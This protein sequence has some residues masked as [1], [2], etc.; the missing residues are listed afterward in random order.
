[1]KKIATSLLVILLASQLSAKSFYEQLCEFNFNWKNYKSIAPEGDARVFKSDKEYI[2]AHLGCVLPI[3]RSNPTLNLSSDELKSRAH[4]IDLLD[5]YRAKGKFPMNYYR[6]ERIPVFIDEHQTHCAVGYLMQQTGYENL[7]QRIAAKDNYVWVKDIKDPEVIEWQKNSGLTIEE[8]KL[9][10]GAYFSYMPDAFTHPN[11][12]EIPQKP[13]VI[14]AFFDKNKHSKKQSVWL[15]GEGENGVLN[16]K[17]IQ[18]YSETLPWIVGYYEKGKRTGQWKEYYQG[19]NLLCRT[20]N[21]RD[22]KLNG[23]RKRFSRDGKIIEEILFKDGNAITKTN[24]DFDDSLT[25]IRKPLDSTLVYTEIYTFNGSLIA[26]G[27]E[28][29]YN[30]G[31]LLWFQNIELTALNTMSISARS[32]PSYSSIQSFN[33]GGDFRPIRSFTSPALVEYKK[34]GDWKYYK[35]YNVIRPKLKTNSVQEILSRDYPHYANALFLN[36]KMFDDLK[37]KSSYDS[38]LISYTDDVLQDFYGYGEQDYA[39]LR[40]HYYAPTKLNE[41]IWDMNSRSIYDFPRIQI[42]GQ[43]NKNKE[44]T[45]TW[46][47]Y[48][49]NQTLYKTETFI[50]PRKEEDDITGY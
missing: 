40:I 11:R 36:V 6:N 45:G 9:I 25:Y 13:E 50:L 15:M 24:Y 28:K 34:E 35:E 4:L 43:Y 1:M 17:W 31:N 3:L 47:Y 5:E 8:L 46:K 2:Q 23:T 19:T 7:A 21:W 10:Q 39:H 12:I 33:Y 37:I 49:K 22:D 42:I 27:H 14:L 30:P 29:V 38:I 20:E 18:N 16:G 44:K 48:D 41:Q 32:A 26:C